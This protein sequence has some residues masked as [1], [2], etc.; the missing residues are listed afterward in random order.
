MMGKFVRGTPSDR[1]ES[2]GEAH[3]EVGSDVV[4]DN[5]G[6][7]ALELLHQSTSEVC[8]RLT[9]GVALYSRMGRVYVMNKTD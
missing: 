7:L 3:L 8:G 5:G 1:Q 2:R 6:D 9:T 4:L